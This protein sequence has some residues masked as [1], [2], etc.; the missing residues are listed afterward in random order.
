[1]ALTVVG[2][3]VVGVLGALAAGLRAEAAATEAREVASLSSDLLTSLTLLPADELLAL[4]GRET[5]LDPPFEDYRWSAR[6]RRSPAV[7]GLVEVRLAVDGPGRSVELL[8][9][10]HRPDNGERP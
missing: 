9:V 3:L 2:M 4:D 1:M 8:T 10:L 6:T 7:P 5:R